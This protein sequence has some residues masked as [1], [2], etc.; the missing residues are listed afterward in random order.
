MSLFPGVFCDDFVPAVNDVLF[1]QLVNELQVNEKLHKNQ[2]R[3]E[4]DQSYYYKTIE[5]NCEKVF[6]QTKKHD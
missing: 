6:L 1:P 3:G 4:E 2:S 5:L